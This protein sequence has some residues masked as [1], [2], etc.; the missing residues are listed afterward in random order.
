MMSPTLPS[1]AFTLAGSERRT[2]S[3]NSSRYD[4]LLSFWMGP[5]L[6]PSLSSQK[7]QDVPNQDAMQT[8]QCVITTSLYEINI[9]DSRLSDE[10]SV[11]TFTHEGLPQ[12]RAASHQTALHLGRDEATHLLKARHRLSF[13]SF[14]EPSK[15]HLLVKRTWIRTFERTSGLLTSLELMKSQ[16]YVCTVRH[17]FMRAHWGC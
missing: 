3:S 9:A 10:G 4:S 15:T 5:M 8:K 13:I 2:R 1:S 12:L 7:Y 16:I 6:T 14:D 17:A 11:I